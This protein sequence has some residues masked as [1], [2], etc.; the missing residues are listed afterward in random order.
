[1][2][3]LG[4]FQQFLGNSYHLV[5]DICHKEMSNKVEVKTCIYNEELDTVLLLW[6]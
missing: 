3:L 1:M 6:I 4:C 5:E 2:S